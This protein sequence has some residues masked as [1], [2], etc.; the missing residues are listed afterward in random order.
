MEKRLFRVP[1]ANFFPCET[2]VVHHES[3]RWRKTTYYSIFWSSFMNE[4]L[5]CTLE[6]VPTKKERKKHWVFQLAK[7]IS[8]LPPQKLAWDDQK[9]KKNSFSWDVNI[10][11]GCKEP[12]LPNFPGEMEC[13]VAKWLVACSRFHQTCWI[14]MG[15]K[16]WWKIF[17][18]IDGRLQTQIPNRIKHSSRR[19]VKYIQ[20]YQNSTKF[21]YIVHPWKLRWHWKIPMWKYGAHLHSWLFFQPIILVFRDVPV[22]FGR[23]SWPRGVSTSFT[24]FKSFFHSIPGRIP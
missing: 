9:K 17:Q 19:N 18:V 20:L 4:L 5:T 7:T 10:F 2:D 12:V 1:G 24:R 21:N 22:P 16:L 14:N 23:G 3:W 6:D 8:V 11:P 13:Q 15:W